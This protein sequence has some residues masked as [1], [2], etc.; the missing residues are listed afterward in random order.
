VQSSACKDAFRHDHPYNHNDDDD[1]DDDDEQSNQS[2]LECTSN[3]Y[4]YDG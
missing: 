2:N 4:S 1:D 3:D